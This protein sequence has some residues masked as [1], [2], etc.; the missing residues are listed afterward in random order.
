MF[1]ATDRTATLQ[2]PRPIQGFTDECHRRKIMATRTAAARH[3]TALVFAADSRLSAD[4]YHD[5]LRQHR[6]SYAQRGESLSGVS[7]FGLFR[8]AR[9]GWVFSGFPIY[10][11][12]LFGGV[13]ADTLNRK[14][15]IVITHS[16]NI[17]PGVVLGI[18][19]LTGAFR[20]GMST[21]STSWP[22]LYKFSADLR[23]KRLF[24]VSCPS[25]IFSMQ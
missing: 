24:P 6:Q 25:R 19:T 14:K 10:Y 1:D 17:L 7:S 22:R 8:A 20:Y 5:L 3:H 13:L 12:R 21:C 9:L 18:L 16:L 2:L 4:F 23:G 11:L 15:L